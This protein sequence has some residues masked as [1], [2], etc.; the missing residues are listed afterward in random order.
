MKVEECAERLKDLRMALGVYS[1]L[2][3]SVDSAFFKCPTVK[4]VIIKTK[5]EASR[6]EELLYNEELED[7]YDQNEG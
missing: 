7:S 4:K 6:L 1:R 5:S 2:Y 3:E